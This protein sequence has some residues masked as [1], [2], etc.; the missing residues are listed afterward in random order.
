[1]HAVS[2]KIAAL[3]LTTV[4]ACSGSS[5]SSRLRMRLRW[6]YHGEALGTSRRAGTG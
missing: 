1:M 5:A 3:N 4:I 6:S 2:E